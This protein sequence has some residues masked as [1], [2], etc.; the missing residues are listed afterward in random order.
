MAS[1]HG[2]HDDVDGDVDDDDDDD[3]NDGD[4]DTTTQVWDKDKSPILADDEDDKSHVHGEDDATT[5]VRDRIHIPSNDG[6]MGIFLSC[7]TT[8]MKESTFVTMMGLAP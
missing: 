6:L 1:G 3:D 8:I 4:D 5:Q 7:R 2:R